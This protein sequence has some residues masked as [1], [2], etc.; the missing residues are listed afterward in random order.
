[1]I[2]VC[3]R[4]GLIGVLRIQSGKTPWTM[5]TMR[6]LMQMRMVMVVDLVHLR[7]SVLIV[8]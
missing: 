6:C 3:F 5:M 8:Y 1:M 7:G 4:Y 2:Y